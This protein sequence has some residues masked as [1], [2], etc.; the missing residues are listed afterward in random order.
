M[1]KHKGELINFRGH[2]L[3]VDE[4]HALLFGVFGALLGANEEVSR[5][6]AKEPHYFLAGLALSY[7][8]GRRLF[9]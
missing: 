3:S 4:G 2:S 6:V 1:H 7:L 8:F 5:V 9:Q